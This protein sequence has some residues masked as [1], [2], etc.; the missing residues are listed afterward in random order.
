ML[1][2]REVSRLISSEEIEG[3][4]WSRRFSFRIHYFLCGS[5]RCYGRQMTT[6]GTAIR[7]WAGRSVSNE[8]VTSLER[9]IV[10]RLNS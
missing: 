2:C 10:D 8:D 9:E 7:R 3:M 1:S 4:G 6:I 5:C